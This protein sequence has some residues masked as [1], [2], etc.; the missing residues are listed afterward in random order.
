MIPVTQFPGGQGLV[1][2]REPVRARQ[3][4]LMITCLCD[5]FFDDAARAAVEC[6]ERAGCEVSC[7]PD[8]TCCGQ[9]AYTTGDWEDFRRI[10]RHVMRV[11]DGDAPIVVA[12]GS[13]AAA[14][15]HEAPIAF[16]GHADL[17]AVRRLASRTWEFSDFLINGLG[18][19]GWSGRLPARIAVHDACHT[20]GTPTIQAVRRLL[21]GIDG[22]EVLDFPDQD[23]CCGFGGVFSVSHPHI[24]SAMG[25]QKVLKVRS[26]SPDYVVSAD[27]SCLMHQQGLAR[28][29]G[30]DYPVR[31]VAQVLRDAGGGPI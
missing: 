29:Q 1:R 8:Q 15:F 4:Q 6:L 28:R 7:P 18:V 24:S 3:A 14:M 23:Q 12:S 13:C 30:L 27:M 31:H 22:L 2:D 20:R 16:E 19:P 21:D 26:A 9:A 5:A 25:H 10:V 11:F 17:P